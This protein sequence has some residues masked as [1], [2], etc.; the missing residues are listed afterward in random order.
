[1]AS[2]RIIRCLRLFRLLQGDGAFSVDEL[3]ERLHV[4]RRT[5]FRDLRILEQS[6]TE[7]DPRTEGESVVRRPGTVSR[8]KEWRGINERNRVT[9]IDEAGEH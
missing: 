3:A 2:S 8:L 7:L 6:K 5:I 4:S 9:L 1:M